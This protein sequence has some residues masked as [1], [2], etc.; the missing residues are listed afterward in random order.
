MHE[1]Q[2]V[3][4]MPARALELLILTCCRVRPVIEMLW[5]DV[6]LVKGVWTC[7]PELMKV[8]DNG[9]C[10][11]QL[12][13]QAVRL[14]KKLQ[15]ENLSRA[16]HSKFVFHT[17]KGDDHICADLHQV[18][19]RMNARRA[20][21]GLSLW[22]DPEAS[23]VLCRDVRVTVHGFRSTFKT[24]ASSEEQPIK[25]SENAVERCLHHRTK[26]FLQA[27]YDRNHYPVQQRIVLQAWANF[28]YS[29]DP[30]SVAE[31]ESEN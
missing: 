12:S 6:D 23:N 30:E 17:R 5:R 7:P 25:F 8:A 15:K 1:L 11:V 9:R 31:D 24:W 29:Y 28:C 13:H 4:G 2:Q 10:Q 16:R 27:C 3:P 19:C 22:T 21:H 14:L 18:I 20:A 26:D